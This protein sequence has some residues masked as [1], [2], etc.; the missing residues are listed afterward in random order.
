MMCSLNLTTAGLIILAGLVSLSSWISSGNASFKKLCLHSKAVIV[1]TLI[2]ATGTLL[3]RM[4]DITWLGHFHKRIS[5]DRGIQHISPGDFTSAGLL[6]VSILM[7]IGLFPGSTGG[8]KTSTLSLRY[9]HTIKGAATNTQP[10]AFHY[11][12]PQEAFQGN[13]DRTVGPGGIHRNLYHVHT[14]AG[15]PLGHSC[16]R[17]PRP[18]GTRGAVHRITPGLSPEQIA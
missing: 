9:S 15:V 10:H 6:T 17:L 16:W 14:G 2:L 11:K 4:E 13:R 7:F 18:F 1:T 8:I 3:I 5:Q 12:I